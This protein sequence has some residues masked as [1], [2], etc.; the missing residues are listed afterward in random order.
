MPRPLFT[1]R[2]RLAAP[3]VKEELDVQLTQ[4]LLTVVRAKMD[5]DLFAD[6]YPLYCEESPH[7]PITTNFAKLKDGL[8]AYNLIYPND[9]YHRTT[10]W[11]TD[12]QLFDLV[13]FLYEH[14]GL[15]EKG[16]YHQYYDHYHLSFD[17]ELG[18]EKFPADVNSFFE[19]NGLAFEL[20]EGEVTRLAPMGLQ[21]ALA[22]TVF[23]TGDP[24]LD[25]LLESARTK[26]LNRDLDVRIEGMEKLWDAWERIKTV[27]AGKDKK[28]Q[29]TAILNKAAIEPNHRQLLETEALAL[30]AI[31][32]GFKIRHTETNKTPITVSAHVDYLFHR[33]FA[34]IRLLLISTN[35]GG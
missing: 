8:S 11:P 14:A 26:F 23:K 16:R 3:R 29:T 30:N 28:A 20:K 21:E 33:M 9:Y 24:E 6:S 10:D 5:E 25:K 15:P 1:E 7:H 35:R 22:E 34:L 31:G 17:K 27:E 19:R 2:N 13:E 18:R 12:P 4:G 32:N